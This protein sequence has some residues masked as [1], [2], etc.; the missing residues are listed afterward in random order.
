MYPTCGV[1]MVD[2]CVLLSLFR[3]RNLGLTRQRHLCRL[4]LGK[5]LTAPRAF[6]LEI[7]RSFSNHQANIDSRNIRNSVDHSREL[8]TALPIFKMAAP[9]PKSLVARHRCA[10]ALSV[11][12]MPKAVGMAV[13][14]KSS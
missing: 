1:E 2:A 9:F 7:Q 3:T 6:C 14:A 12:N 5:F 11:V 10:R 8:E 13:I 4:L